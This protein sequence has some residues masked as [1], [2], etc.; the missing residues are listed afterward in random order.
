[1]PSQIN[2]DLVDDDLAE[3]EHLFIDIREA[4]DAGLT[5]IAQRRGQTDE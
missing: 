3:L 1:M 4:I 5:L 2:P